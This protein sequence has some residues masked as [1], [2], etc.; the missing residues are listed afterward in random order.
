MRILRRESRKRGHNNKRHVPD[1]HVLAGGFSIKVDC[2]QNPSGTGSTW[3]TWLNN[4]CLKK[5]QDST[6]TILPTGHPVSSRQGDP[7]GEGFLSH[8]R[9]GKPSS[10]EPLVL[11]IPSYPALCRED[12][13]SWKN[14]R[15]SIHPGMLHP[16]AA[17][18]TC[19]S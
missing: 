14:G 6:T 17:S 16:P 13:T 12:N 1:A 19:L 15:P 4:S 18:Y 7:L 8:F 2:V 3:S 9:G 10:K 11:P 5:W